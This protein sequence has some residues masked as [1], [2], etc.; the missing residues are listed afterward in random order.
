MPILAK[1]KVDRHYMAHEV[2]RFPFAI[3]TPWR[4]PRCHCLFSPGHGR[5]PIPQNFIIR[6]KT[7]PDR[8]SG[9]DFALRSNYL[10][11]L[12]FITGAASGEDIE[13]LKVA[14]EYLK[15]GVACYES[16]A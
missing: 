2:P 14:Q 3:W 12:C 11:W 5:E 16:R 8:L 13:R 9:L 6:H 7:S 10:G 1:V 4:S 15:K